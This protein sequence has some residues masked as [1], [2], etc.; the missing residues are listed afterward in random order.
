MI[1]MRDVDYDPEM[2]NVREYILAFD[3]WG[4][5]L[6]KA[7][8]SNRKWASYTGYTNK[9]LI[10]KLKDKATEIGRTPSR[11][12]VDKDENMPN[13]NTYVY[14][15]GSWNNALKAAKLPTN[16]MQKKKKK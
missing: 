10:Q 15:F 1:S 16:N 14:R 8:I 2:P 3:S 13:G 4:N 5:A 12:M 6:K 11:A 7:G 9:E